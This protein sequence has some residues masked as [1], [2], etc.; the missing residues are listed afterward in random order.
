M[1]IES[2]EGAATGGFVEDEDVWPLVPAEGPKEVAC[3][4]CVL[5]GTPAVAKA[6]V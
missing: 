5:E 4:P 2:V 3:A 6:Y 1:G